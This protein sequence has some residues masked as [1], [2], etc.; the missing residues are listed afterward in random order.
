MVGDEVLGLPHE[1]GQLVH[2][3][4]AA[5]QVPQELPPQRMPCELQECRR[6]QVSFSLKRDHV[7][8]LHQAGW[9]HQARLLDSGLCQRHRAGTTGVGG[10]WGWV[11][12]RCEGWWRWACRRNR[13]KTRP[14]EGHTHTC[15][16]SYGRLRVGLDAANRPTVPAITAVLP[17]RP[18]R[19][20]SAL[21]TRP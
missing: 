8:V 15:G 13:K 20:A 4:V 14:R 7:P 3:A 10:G 12:G 19:R 2:S 17:A 16:S 21:P 6:R 5:G 1:S 11:A 9:M 18:P